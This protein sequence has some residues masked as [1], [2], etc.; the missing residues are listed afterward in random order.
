MGGLGG[1]R[2]VWFGFLRWRIR[3]VNAGLS[4]LLDVSVQNS[5]CCGSSFETVVEHSPAMD[6]RPSVVILE[7]PE[8]NGPF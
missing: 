3:A 6:R 4:G 2:V 8:V 5:S 7:L 1:Y